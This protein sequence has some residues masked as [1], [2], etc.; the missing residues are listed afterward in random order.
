MFVGEVKLNRFN[1]KIKKEVDKVPKIVLNSIITLKQFK[2]CTGPGGGTRRLHHK[3]TGL[4]EI[5]VDEHTSKGSESRINIRCAFD[6]GEI[7]STGR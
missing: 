5:P 3:H 4:V 2:R 1:T 6:G 7:G